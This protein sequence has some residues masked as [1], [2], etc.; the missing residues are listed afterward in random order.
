MN[1]KRPI[2][3][4]FAVIVT[5]ALVAAFIPASQAPVQAVSTSV[6]ISQVYGGGGGSGY[7]LYDYVELFNLGASSTDLTGWSLQYGSATGNFGSFAAI[8]FAFPAG[9]TLDP[10]KYLL[11]QLGTAGTAGLPLPVTP[12]LTAT[13]EYVYRPAAR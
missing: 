2:F 1:V 11:L 8:S 12:D 4:L 3:R 7:Y 5:L 13:L 9:T 10:G 6:V